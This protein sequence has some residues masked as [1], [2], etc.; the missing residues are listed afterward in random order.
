MKNL[1]ARYGFQESLFEAMKMKCDAMKPM[2]IR[3]TRT[4]SQKTF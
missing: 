4:H 2:E 3:G 1:G